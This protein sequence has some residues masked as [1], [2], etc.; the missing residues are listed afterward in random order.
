MAGFRSFFDGGCC[1]RIDVVVVAQDRSTVVV[2]APF[3]VVGNN[4]EGSL[5]GISVVGIGCGLEEG[6]NLVA[7]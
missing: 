4:G 5:I 7:R 1:I 2:V 3:F 6:N